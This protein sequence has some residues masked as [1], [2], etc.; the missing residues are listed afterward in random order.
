MGGGSEVTN[1][2]PTR[3]NCTNKDC[4]E[5]VNT[6][7]KNSQ[8]TARIKY[9][10]LIVLGIIIRWQIIF[11][12]R[13]IDGHCLRMK[14]YCYMVASDCYQFKTVLVSLAR[15]L[16]QINFSLMQIE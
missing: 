6:I 13:Y 8:I 15:L 14:R 4:G 7:S 3:Q 9:W 16:M 1:T 10:L 2:P 11:Y 12:L 5:V